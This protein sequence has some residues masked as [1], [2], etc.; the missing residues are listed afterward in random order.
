M[1]VWSSVQP[2]LCRTSRQVPCIRLRYSDSDSGGVRVGVGV[3]KTKF[4]RIGVIEKN[5]FGVNVEVTV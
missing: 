1:Y 3:T 4:F 5:Y 2:M